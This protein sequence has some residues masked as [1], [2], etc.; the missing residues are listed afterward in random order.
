[1]ATE[2]EIG[3]RLRVTAT[4][5]EVLDDAGKRIG[6]LERQTEQFGK[7]GQ[8]AFGG[9]S[10]AGA[11]ATAAIG[12][13]TAAAY[14]LGRAFTESLKQQDELNKL[15]Q[16]AGIATR[17]L[18]GLRVVAELGGVS[19]EQFGQTAAILSRNLAEAQNKSSESGRVFSALGIE[20]KR[21]DGALRGVS[22]ILADVA[23]RFQDL[24]NGP[25]KTAAAMRLLGRSGADLI[26]IL[27]GGSEAIREQIAEA[28]VLGVTFDEK[29]GA[30]SERFNDNMTRLQLATEGA[31]KSLFNE[32]LPGLVAVSDA[33]V[34]ATE[35]GDTFVGR[36]L[37]NIAGT[38][39]DLL[40]FVAGAPSRGGVGYDTGAG[41][42]GPQGFVGPVLPPDEDLRRRL[43]AALASPERGGRGRGGGGSGG[44][45]QDS[46]A[47][48][49]QADLD[50]QIAENLADREKERLALLDLQVTRRETALS[51]A[52]ED[53][54]LAQRAGATQQD[55]L[56]IAQ[57][58]DT[59]E[60][61]RLA[62]ARERIQTEI[63]GLLQ[64]GPVVSA[65]V[66]QLQ[67]ELEAV[68]TEIARGP[69]AA[70][71]LADEF[72]R[73]REESGK[74]ED[75]FRSVLNALQSSG[76]RIDI[77]GL[78]KGVLQV[79]ATDLFAKS[80]GGLAERAGIGSRDS[81]LIDIIGNGIEKG[82]ASV[83]N[84][85]TISPSVSS[86][87]AAGASFGDVTAG[88]SSTAASAGGLGGG[89]AMASIY[90]AAVLAAIG[91]IEGAI[92][93]AK[94]AKRK[95]GATDDDAAGAALG[96]WFE[97]AFDAV[98]LGSVGGIIGSGARGI[99]KEAALAN[100]WIL[101]PLEGLIVT[102]LSQAPTRGTNIKRELNELYSDAN[103][104][105]QRVSERGGRAGVQTQGIESA[106]NQFAFDELAARG[107]GGGGIIKGPDGAGIKL[108]QEI[109]AAAARS[110]EVANLRFNE[111]LAVGAVLGKTPEDAANITNAITNN[112]LLLDVS[113][114]EARRQMKKLADTAGID[115]VSGLEE[116]N[117]GFLASKKTS[118][119]LLRLQSASSGLV[120]LFNDELPAAINVE[121]IVTRATNQTGGIDINAVQW[122]IRGAVGAFNLREQIADSRLGN[123]DLR[124]RDAEIRR[125]IASIDRQLDIGLNASGDALS[126]AQR[127]QLLNQRAQLG[128]QL[129]DVAGQRYTGSARRRAQESAYAIVEDT[130][131]QLEQLGAE[132]KAT[133]EAN[134]DATKEQ[135]AA[136]TAN[137]SQLKRLGDLIERGAG[138]ISTLDINLASGDEDST[139]AALAAVKRE[140]AAWI[141][142]PEFRAAVKAAV[143]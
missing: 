78:L 100:A 124:A 12:L 141:K 66:V 34:K 57:R 64:F 63:D 88:G 49:Q 62:A 14:Q 24:P 82:F 53:L 97:G 92:E 86:T 67:G 55:Q 103:L 31:S 46:D 47:A 127:E 22:E 33:M 108:G 15:A 5:L 71:G 68:N 44:S 29:V 135:S 23:D 54:S 104:P 120:K 114:G 16:S 27:N 132:T 96:G 2:R 9:I 40:E 38:A 142:S 39:S 4:G 70:R 26:P 19:M 30:A 52:E 60:R 137:T 25:E 107:Y 81:S 74:L 35:S 43:S 116:L 3:V 128:F 106:P 121:N 134:T 84:L 10:A 72:A 140:L 17:E 36:A 112:L 94:A 91:G 59:L 99:G 76:G 111:S 50:K 41:A 65:E 113:L 131:A 87:G 117:N 85:F 139:A 51:L 75:S 73:A 129:V 125:R 83:R 56:A 80:L 126:E 37:R 13:V 58:I 122:G 118:E 69:Q 32:L 20:V 45:G 1:M 95:V 7:S 143:K 42:G 102:L 101:G 109:N 89:A 133:T 61:E 123:L 21:S 130:A 18:S 98:G 79:D 136:Q 28:E 138:I 105:R 77:G 119:D 115:L 11:A 93:S 110:P 90:V 48:R 8:T 6:T